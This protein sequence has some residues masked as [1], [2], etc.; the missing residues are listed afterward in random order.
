[1]GLI[2]GLIGVAIT[3]RRDIAAVKGEEALERARQRLITDPLLRCQYLHGEYGRNATKA[4]DGCGLGQG[5][6][7]R[8]LTGD[9]LRAYASLCTDSTLAYVIES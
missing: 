5:E 7:S 6:T 3:L 1:M 8:P 2:L 4:C 9:E